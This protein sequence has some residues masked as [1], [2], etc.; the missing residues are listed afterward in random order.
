MTLSKNEIALLK[1][2]ESSPRKAMKINHPLLIPIVATL[3]LQGCL[4]RNKTA[5]QWYELTD[6]G[7]EVIAE[8]NADER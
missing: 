5:S 1:R 3:T 6:K 7:K 4:K 8:A 2:I